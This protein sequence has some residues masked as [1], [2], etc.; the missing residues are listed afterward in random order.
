MT[1][2]SHPEKKAKKEKD[3]KELEQ[4]KALMNEMASAIQLGLGEPQKDD[5]WDIYSEFY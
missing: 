5:Q 3:D 4:L 2:Y 1:I